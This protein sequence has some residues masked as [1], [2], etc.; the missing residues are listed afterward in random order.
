MTELRFPVASYREQALRGLS[1]LPPFSP[2]LNKLLTSLA[3]EDVSYAELAALIERDTVMSANLLRLVNSAAY[4]RRGTVSSV[5]HAV[6]LIGIHKLRNSAMS[7]SITQ[8]WTKVKT[9]PSWSSK[10]FNLH[11][12]AVAAMADLLAQELPVEYPEGAFAAGLLHD[13]GK[14]LIAISLPEK[15]EEICKVTAVT[16]LDC[17]EHEQEV[18]DVT[19]TELTAIALTKWS[20]PGPIVRAAQFHHQPE[21]DVST[22]GF[23]LLSHAVQTADHFSKQMGIGLQ[24]R[25]KDETVAAEALMSLGV[26]THRVAAVMTAFE[27]EIEAIRSAI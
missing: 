24:P 22:A 9:P 1:A 16:G 18:L 8:L 25:E 7:V 13:L 4:G 6:S 27:T 26:Q 5:R 23:P 14:M 20:L 11:S 3:N 2:V 17:Q 19:H 10:R 21:A 15:Y 12:I